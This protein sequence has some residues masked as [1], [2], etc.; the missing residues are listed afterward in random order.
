[1]QEADIGGQLEFPGLPNRQ[2]GRRVYL[3]FRAGEET[4]RHEF[5]LTTPLGAVLEMA[6]EQ[7]A[8]VIELSGNTDTPNALK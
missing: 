4:H 1:M 8:S 5:D 7:G 6:R 2:P 3:V